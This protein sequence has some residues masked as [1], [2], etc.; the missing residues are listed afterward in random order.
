[1]LRIKQFLPQ[2]QTTVLDHS[3][4]SMDITLCNFWVFLKQ[5]T[6]LKGAHFVSK[7]EINTTV[8]RALKDF[9]EGDHAK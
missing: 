1:M 4:Y 3:S 2:K 6:R 9:K 8:T 7:S 5:K